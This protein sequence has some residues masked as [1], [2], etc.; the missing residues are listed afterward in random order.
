[1]VVLRLRPINQVMDDEIEHHENDHDDQER[2]A[3][4]T[5]APRP[6]CP[7]PGPSFEGG[8]GRTALAPRRAVRAKRIGR[9]APR[10]AANTHGVL[11][12]R[13]EAPRGLTTESAPT[14]TWRG[15]AIS[16]LE[17]GMVGGPPDFSA[18]LVGSKSRSSLDRGRPSRYCVL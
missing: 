1:D 13:Q 15:R 18:P 8:A 10:I 4:L 14:V 11:V 2:E 6:A 7:R 3:A 5:S 17:P 12:F 16:V 9:R